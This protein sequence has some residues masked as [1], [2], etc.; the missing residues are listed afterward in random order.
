METKLPEGMFSPRETRILETLLSG[1]DVDI[2][3]LYTRHVADEWNTETDPRKRQQHAGAIASQLNRKLQ[4]LGFKIVPGVARR[5][6]R[7]TQPEA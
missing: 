3:D 5:T 7:L 1:E 2:D 4:K 6:Y